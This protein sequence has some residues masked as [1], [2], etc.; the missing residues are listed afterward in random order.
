MNRATLTLLSLL[1]ICALSLVAAQQR[2]PGPVV[3]EHAVA[4]LHKI[5]IRLGVVDEVP[6]AHIP[7]QGRTQGDGAPRAHRSHGTLGQK[8]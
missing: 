4:E 7:R 6:L 1:L 5:R 8:H 2:A 3:F